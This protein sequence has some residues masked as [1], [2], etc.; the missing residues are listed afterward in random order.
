M[1]MTAPSF[2]VNVMD[3][4]ESKE[5]IANKTL[6]ENNSRDVNKS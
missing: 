6:L 2:N 1:E 4:N 5:I 3:G